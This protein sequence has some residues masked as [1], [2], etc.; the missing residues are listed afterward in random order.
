MMR[1]P[2]LKKALQG[3]Q[4]ISALS[5]KL[6]ITEGVIDQPLG[7]VLD[8]V[9]RRYGRVDPLPVRCPGQSEKRLNIS[10]GQ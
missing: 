3:D 7:L 4:H 1:L 5:Q 8:H 10:A 2:S 9:T 6:D